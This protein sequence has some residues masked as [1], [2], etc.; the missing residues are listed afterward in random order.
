MGNLF[1]STEEQNNFSLSSDIQTN[2]ESLRH[3][4]HQL[5]LEAQEA[6]KQSQHE[7]QF[8]SRAQAKVLS[9]KKVNLYQQ[10]NEKNRQAAALIFEQNNENRPKNF[11]DLHGLYVA[12]ALTYLRQKLD[13]CRSEGILEVTVITGMGNNSPNNIAKIK[14]EVEKFARENRLKVTP[15]PGHLVLDLTIDKQD[16]S[17]SQSKSN[18]CLIL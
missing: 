10:M 3:E 13:Q 6:A 7:Y 17:T 4:A 16:Q 2:A 9:T 14:P 1:S 12:E 18:E 5:R 11:I 8:G 15:H